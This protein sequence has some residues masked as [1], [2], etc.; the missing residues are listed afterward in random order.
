MIRTDL[1]IE[2]KELWERDP[3]ETTQLHGVRAREEGNITYVEILNK[4]GSQALG[5]PI[6][7]Y[8]TL[9]LPAYDRDPRVPAEDLAR[10]LSGSLTV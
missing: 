8:L 5:K 6:G 3:K 7:T 4:E 10:E 1:A 2:A 9:S